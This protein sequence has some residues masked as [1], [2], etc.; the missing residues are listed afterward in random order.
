MRFFSRLAISFCLVGAF[1]LVGCARTSPAV[2]TWTATQGPLSATLTLKE[3]AQGH[4]FPRQRQAARS[5]LS[6]N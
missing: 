4:S 1:L 3:T 6:G 5:R 2:G